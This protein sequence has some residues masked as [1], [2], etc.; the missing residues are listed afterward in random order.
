M[1]E[2]EIPNP[3]EVHERAENPFTRTVALF[4]AV[5]AVGLAIASFGGK[6]AGKEI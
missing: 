3:H 5:Y 1:A 6:D 2:I 4:V